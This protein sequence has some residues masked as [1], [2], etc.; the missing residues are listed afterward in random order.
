MRLLLLLVCCLVALLPDTAFAA[1]TGSPH[2]YTCDDEGEAYAKAQSIPIEWCASS[3]NRNEEVIKH[4]TSDRYIKRYQYWGCGQAG[5][6]FT[7]GYANWTGDTCDMRE[8][9]SGWLVDDDPETSD[10]VCDNGCMMDPSFEID[11]DG[12]YQNVFYPTGDVCT[13]ADIPPPQPDA[14]GDGVADADDAFPDDPDE[15]ADTDGDGTGDNEDFSPEDPTDGEDDGTG[16]ETDNQSNGGGTCAAPPTCSGDGIQCNQ[17]FQ[18]WQ[19]RCSG[20]A[21][22]D[23]DEGDDYDSPP[24][25]G[26]ETATPEDLQVLSSKEIGPGLFDDSGWLSR[27]CPPIPTFE[28][29]PL[30][31]YTPNINGWCE[32]I[33]AIGGLIMMLAALIALRIMVD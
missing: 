1:C 32:L 31:S 20:A 13:D 28:L 23:D 29:G 14:D 4:E 10:L 27:S 19:I 16:D 6:W 2:T 21:G 33:E 15:S 3:Y 18:L 22:G 12:S 25:S 24:T 5:F 11:V 7:A 17:L 26:D 9:Q 30:G 8:S